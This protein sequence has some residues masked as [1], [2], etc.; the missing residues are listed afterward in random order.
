MINIKNIIWKVISMNLF[1]FKNRVALISG[2]SSGLGADAA[3]AYAEHGADVA[4]LARRKDRLDELAAEINAKDGGR[5]FAVQADVSDEESVKNAVQQVVD[6]YGKIDILFNN[7]GVAVSG[8][9]ETNTDAE[10]D[11]AID[12][13]IKGIVHMSK[14][15]VPVM[16]KQKYGRIVNTA[17]VN[18]ILADKPESLWRHTYNMT[19]AGVI[20]LTKGMAAS[21]A[22]DGITVNALGPGLFES[23]MTKDTLFKAQEFLNMYNAL[24]PSGR[25]ANRG[26]L[27]APLLFFS[28]E[29]ASYVTGQYLLV[30]GGFS[31]V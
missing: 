11:K 3:R 8:S 18:A 21:Y 25:P 24:S 23:E 26:E 12:V 29:G 19:K 1:D 20:G 5:A 2:A 14:Y 4:I 22:I 31:I 7:A 17:S 6:H 27:N 9:V 16:R 10:W 28:S 30:D 13:N 15:V